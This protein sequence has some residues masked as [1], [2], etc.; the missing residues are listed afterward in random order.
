M[1]PPFLHT[2]V[3]LTYNLRFLFFEI[4]ID[5]YNV[6]KLLSTPLIGGRAW[7]ESH[8]TQASLD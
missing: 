8:V 5:V 4:F 2:V 6:F 7:A 1:L 3:S